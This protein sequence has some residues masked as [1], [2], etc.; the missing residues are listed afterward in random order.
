M[1][2]HVL[3]DSCGRG[4]LLNEKNTYFEGRYRRC[5]AC[6]AHRER[7]RR[8]RQ[9]EDRPSYEDR[10]RARIEA[11]TE[12]TDGCWLWRGRATPYGSTYFHGRNRPVHRVQW[13]LTFGE[14]PDGVLVCHSCDNPICVN[15][16]H[17]FLG[18]PADNSADMVAKGRGRGNRSVHLRGEA[19]P[20]AKMTEDGVRELRRLWKAGMGSPELS[21]RFGINARNAWLIAT[22]RSWRHVQDDENP[23]LQLPL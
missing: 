1:G 4:H 3:M 12:K 2:Y 22:R 6:H 7:N 13:M 14:V 11:R 17:L 16:A 23:V 21:R 9:R 19:N 15:P 5:R 18:T 20:L 10:V 8:A